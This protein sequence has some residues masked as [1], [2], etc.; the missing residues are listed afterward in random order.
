MRCNELIKVQSIV[1]EY[2]RCPTMFVLA[3]EY[4]F[5]SNQAFQL[6]GTMDVIYLR[7]ERHYRSIHFSQKESSI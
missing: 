6:R 1:N 3:R 7:Q 2:F 5:L 4:R